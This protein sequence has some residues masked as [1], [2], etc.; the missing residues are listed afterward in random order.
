MLRP[1]NRPLAIGSA[2]CTI[3]GTIGV[4]T[5]VTGERQARR[6][7]DQSEQRYRN[8]FERNLAG[9]YRTTHRVH[10]C[11]KVGARSMPVDKRKPYRRWLLR[12]IPKGKRTKD[13]GPLCNLSCF[14]NNSISSRLW[15]F[16]KP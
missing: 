5:N 12:W 2:P 8:L 4:A 13:P 14:G 7:A 11:R 9:V 6:A 15:R 1:S 10:C 3:V 16:A